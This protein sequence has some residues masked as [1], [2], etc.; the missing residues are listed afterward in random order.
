MIASPTKV[1]AARKKFTGGLWGVP[2]PLRSRHKALHEFMRRPP[3]QAEALAIALGFRGSSHRHQA[4]RNHPS[5]A[6]PNEFAAAA[7]PTP[8]SAHSRPHR[9]VAA[10]KEWKL[11]LIAAARCPAYAPALPSISARWSLCRATGVVLRVD[12]GV[13]VFVATSDTIL[14]RNVAVGEKRRAATARLQGDLED[15]TE[16]DA[17][18]R[19]LNRRDPKRQRAAL[20]LARAKEREANVRR[21]YAHKA[22]RIVNSADVIALEA[23]KL[24]GMT[25]SA[26]DTTEKPGRNVAAKTGLNRVVLDAGFGLLEQMIVAKAEKA[27]RTIVRVD[28][29]CSSQECS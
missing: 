26:R 25:R 27:A 10:A 15:V 29:K 23:L 18:G 24:L 4:R 22:S 16:R 11:E 12:R 2:V 7:T 21:D 20:R 13:H 3:V 14:I 19:C 8:P 1:R 9:D 5:P 17:G 6:P 28:P